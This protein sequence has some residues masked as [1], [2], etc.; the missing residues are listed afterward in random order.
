MNKP[1]QGREMQHKRAVYLHRTYSLQDP[2]VE[3]FKKTNNPRSWSS[4]VLE[5]L[6]AKG[7]ARYG[8]FDHTAHSDI[9]FECYRY[10]RPIRWEILSNNEIHILPK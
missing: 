8:M 9:A 1:D 4:R 2:A 3:V 5:K 10:H 6:S 7:D